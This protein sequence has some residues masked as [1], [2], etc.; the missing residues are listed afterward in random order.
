[1]VKG[2]LNNL[3]VLNDKIQICLG[4]DMNPPIGHVMAGKKLRDKGL[5]IFLG[6]VE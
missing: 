2:D 4:G 3:L 6:M 1:M 5:H